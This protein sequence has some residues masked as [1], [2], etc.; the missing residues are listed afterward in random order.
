M[1]PI[2]DTGAPLSIGSVKAATKL[3]AFLQIEL[4]LED[5]SDKEKTLHA[6]GLDGH[7]AR[8]LLFLWKLEV[9]DQDN[10]KFVLK[11]KLTD[12]DEPLVIGLDQIENAQMLNDESVAKLGRNHEATFG[13]Y[14][15]VDAG[16][17]RQYLDVF[18]PCVR[19][20]A[21]SVTPERRL[22]IKIHHYG[23]L[24]VPEMETLLKR[25][26]LWSDE[27][28]E[29]VERVVA[30]CSG[31]PQVGRPLANTQ[32]SLRK[33]LRN[34]NEEVQ[35]DFLYVDGDIILHLCDSG[36]GYSDGEEVTDRSLKQAAIIFERKWIHVHGAPEIV[37][38][39]PEFNR[40]DFKAL[41]RRHTIQFSSRPARRHQKI[42]VVER[43]NST[44]RHIQQKMQKSPQV[45]ALGKQTL[46]SR[47][48]FISNTIVGDKLHSAFAAKNGYEPS[49]L[50]LPAQEVP[51]ALRQAQAE[52]VASRAVA[53]AMSSNRPRPLERKDISEHEIILGYVTAG[54]QGRKKWERFRVEKPLEHLVEARTVR[55]QRRGPIVRLAYEDIR[56][57]PRSPLAQEEILACYDADEVA[58]APE[59][60]GV[61]PATALLAE[62]HAGWGKADRQEFSQEILENVYDATEGKNCRALPGC[63]QGIMDDAYQ[64]EFADNWKPHI[65]EI[66]RSGAKNII[67]THVLYRIKKG[68]EEP[69][70]KAKARLVLRGDLDAEKDLLRTDA[71][72]TNFTAIRFLLSLCQLEALEPD[73]VLAAD[74]KGAFLQSGPPPRPIVVYPPRGHYK[75]AKGRRIVWKLSTL[76]YG[77]VDAPRHWSIACTDFFRDFGLRPVSGMPEVWIKQT[78]TSTRLFDVVLVRAT[79]DVLAAGKG[80]DDFIAAFGRRFELSKVRRLSD[81]P[82]LFFGAT[83]TACSD[84][85]RME[86]EPIKWEPLL[87]SE[88][89][90]QREDDVSE[91]ERKL[92]RSNAGKII[93]FGLGV[94]LPACFLA[95]RLMSELPRATVNSLIVAEEEA[96]LVARGKSVWFPKN[97]TGQPVREVRLVTYAD[98]SHPN[99]ASYGRSGIITC[100]SPLRPEEDDGDI[101][102]YVEW[103]SK[104]QTRV[105][106]SPF[107]AEVIAASDADDDSFAMKLVLEDIGYDVYNVLITDSHGLLDTTTTEKLAREKRARRTIQRIRDS[108]V[109]RDL[110][111][112]RWLEGTR[113]IA[114]AGTK[115]NYEMWRKLGQHV[116]QGTMPVDF[117][118]S[119]PARGDSWREA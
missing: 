8:W 62:A 101:A 76:P 104:K 92:I 43:K 78:E 21:G 47:A 44:L 42:G 5:L 38:A 57:L 54:S 68:E 18:P 49:W 9:L 83:I 25:A 94:S 119:A 20:L 73:D 48:F 102:Y 115:S 98:A 13:T 65:K 111:E 99:E 19:T 52:L 22:A 41:L 29:E 110:E 66:D 7:G 11:F 93:F 69:K 23:H 16:N 53:K 117:S 2:I 17:V 58:A 114:D 67:P 59:E 96:A 86:M 103:Q 31:C 51:D 95:S 90:K 70:F 45:D 56:K 14:L 39:D 107:G 77:T 64:K 55:A 28:K 61:Q 10:R 72:T 37:A 79:D 27:M 109:N 75:S 15:A 100:L 60:S 26:Q 30:N 33:A 84:G 1:D 50:G 116:E 108:F 6:W 36:H 105:S 71:N 87:S 3:A 74:V 88:R 35:V 80:V 34:F 63:P 112:V 113:N 106:H 46:I 85:I 118:Q 24:T 91:E 89:R 12:G 82:T 40:G 81:G 4:V 32:L 97:K